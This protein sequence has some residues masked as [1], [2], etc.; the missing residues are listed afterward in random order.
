MSEGPLNF[1]GRPKTEQE[2]SPLQLFLECG[3]SGGG[4]C[5]PL[6]G[7]TY[8]RWAFRVPKHITYNR[9]IVFLN[10]EFIG[11]R[12]YTD[13]GPVGLCDHS[14]GTEIP[15]YMGLSASI[16]ADPETT[17]KAGVQL[18]GALPYEIEFLANKI[19]QPT[20]PA[21]TNIIYAYLWWGNPNT[22]NEGSVMANDSPIM[23]LIKHDYDIKI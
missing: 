15:F 19:P 20:D 18:G 6:I 7:S 17:A 13:G 8:V 1:K 4:A 5:L 14:L 21:W 9:K 2:Y 10:P 22:V 11:V 16:A 23:Q 3:G 12:I